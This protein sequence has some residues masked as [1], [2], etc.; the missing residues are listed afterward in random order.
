LRAGKQRIA[1]LEA[2]REFVESESKK[3]IEEL[4]QEF[5]ESENTSMASSVVIQQLN[6]KI[7]ELEKV[8]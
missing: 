8:L 7:A 3:L 5:I 1:S 2:E 4:T 6:S